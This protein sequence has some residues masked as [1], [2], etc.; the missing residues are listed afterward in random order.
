MPGLFVRRWMMREWTREE[1][2]RV[3]QDPE[4]IRE[5]Y[6]KIAGTKYRQIFHV[7]PVTGLS[8]DPNGFAKLGD[9][10]HLFYQWC[11]WGAVHGL[12]YWYHV[13]SRDLVHWKNEGIGLKPDTLYDS[14]GVHSGSAY[15]KDGEMYIFYTGNHRDEE[16]IRTPYTCAAEMKDGKLVKLAEPLFGPMSGYTEH[17]RDPKLVWNEE[18][19]KYYIFIGAQTAEKHGAV[20]VYVSDQLLTGWT[21]AGELKIPG[22]EDFGGMWECPSVIRISGKDVLIFSPQYTKLPGRGESTNHTVYI[23]GMMDYD[24]LT[25]TPESGYQYLDHG[26]DFYAAQAAGSNLDED[27]A[28]VIAWIGLPDNHYPT[29]EI[30]WEGSMTIPRVLSLKDGKLI[31]EPVRKIAEL[32]EEE[33]P[34]DSSLPDACEMLIR[35]GEEACDL[36]LFADLEGNG[37]LRITA[38]PA[39]KVL[40]VDKSGME[41]SF[42]KEVGEV[43]E[44]PLDRELEDMR[45]FID[46]CS[47][48]IFINGGE[49]TFTAHVYPTDVEHNYRVNADAEVKI[50]TMKPAVTDDFVV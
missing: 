3:L 41:L 12:K 8:S 48:E 29:A 7:Q 28:A 31:Q 9:T 35:F 25:F 4:E 20:L 38:D 16:W 22:Y 21:F 45:I 15:V 39:K 50:Y 27:H 37:G 17:Q 2:Y 36:A 44:V 1:R 18:K 40:T 49:Q 13:S 10:W 42:N 5:I 43:L 30:D 33:I 11:P 14:H 6:D 47:A 26:F 32:R 23:I 34:G 24:T 46:H 19:Q